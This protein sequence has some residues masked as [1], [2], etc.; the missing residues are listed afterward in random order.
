MQQ[1]AS[2]CTSCGAFPRRS[3][4]HEEAYQ[5]SVLLERLRTSNFA[6]TDQE[7]S[8][9]RHTVLPTVSDDISSIDS[10][11][12]SLHEVI[13]SMEEER[14][15]LLNVQKQ[16]SNLISLHRTLPSEIWSKIFLYTLP[17]DYD[18][19]AFDASGSI[20]QLS[21]VCQRWR[22]VALSLQSFWST[23]D[24]HFPNAAQ[25]EGDVQRLE[26]VI[27]RS[28]QGPLDVSL[29]SGYTQKFSSDPSILKRIL[30]I[31]LA[32]SYRWR[33]LH[34]SDR[35]GRLNMLYAPLHNRLP[36][37]QCLSLDC[38]QIEPKE[39]SVFKDCPC[40][41]KLTLGEMKARRLLNFRGTRLPS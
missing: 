14:E 12:A 30:D 15:R 11:V 40:L 28:C 3:L 18:S 37:L 21:H 32:E 35:P 39:Q 38:V 23:I 4:H 7:I 1:I 26:A 19:N 24:L 41:T 2:Q 5:S 34:L 10:Q 31:V 36:C 9:I 16:Y 6:A 25:H 20:W 17:D 13:R 29:K 22:N 27:Q 8:H 33:V